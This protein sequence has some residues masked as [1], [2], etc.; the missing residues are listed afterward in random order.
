VLNV[1]IE[2]DRCPAYPSSL[3]TCSVEDA[4]EDHPAE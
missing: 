3:L 1:T 4:A 2:G